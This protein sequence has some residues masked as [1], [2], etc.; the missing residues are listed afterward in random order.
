MLERL[1][2]EMIRRLGAPG[3]SRPRLVLAVCGWGYW[4]SAFRSG[5]LARGEDL[6]QD[7]VRDGAKAGI[8]VLISGER[9]LTTSRL[10]GGIANRIF[11]PAGSS[12]E[13]RLAWPRTA[14]SGDTFPAGWLSWVPSSGP[15][16]RWCM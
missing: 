16:R 1:A 6:V 15:L 5:P 10:F 11:F 13:E 3:I 8:A 2:G 4:V 14:R 12:D 9:E 7:I